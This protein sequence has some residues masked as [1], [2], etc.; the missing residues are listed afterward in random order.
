MAKLL[1]LETGAVV[2]VAPEAD[3]ALT[4]DQD[5]MASPIELEGVRTIALHFPKFKDGRAFSQA[6]ILRQHFGFSGEL[7][8]VGNVIPDQALYL[9]RVG[10]DVVEIE[11]TARVGAFQDALKCYRYAYQQSV[12]GVAVPQLRSAEQ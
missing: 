4:E 3:L 8:A 1:Q 10:F 2:D 12:S 9:R 7:R 11:D 6:L 5:L